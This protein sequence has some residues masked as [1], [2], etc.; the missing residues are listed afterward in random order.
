MSVFKHFKLNLV[1][2][3]NVKTEI[4]PTKILIEICI[5]YFLETIKKK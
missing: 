5:K 2:K 3:I 1:Y 4:Y